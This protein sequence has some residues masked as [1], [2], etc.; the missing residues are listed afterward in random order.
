MA[1][2]ATDLRGW[3]NFLSTLWADLGATG[4]DLAL[5]PLIASCR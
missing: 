5:S 4:A 1:A 2:E 3:L